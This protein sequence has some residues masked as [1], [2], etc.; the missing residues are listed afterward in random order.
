[1]HDGQI[2]IFRM[3]KHYDRFARSL[4]RMCM[5]VVPKDIFI[6]GLSQLLQ[7]DNAWIPAERGT[8]L[9]LRPF[10]FASEARFV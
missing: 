6:D 5:A 10:V 8:A 4:E 9:Y 7:L 1:M 3:E 2:N